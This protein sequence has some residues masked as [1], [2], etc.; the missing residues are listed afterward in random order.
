M[1]TMQQASRA[2]LELPRQVNIQLG[3]GRHVQLRRLDWISFELL[4]QEFCTLVGSL[5][6]GGID[7]GDDL[8]KQLGTAPQLVLKLASL[9]SGLDEAELSRWEHGSV[10][11]L[12]AAALEL[13]FNDPAGLRDF[14][15]ALARLWQHAQ[16]PAD[17]SQ[18]PDN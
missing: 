16:Q 7:N 8:L 6:D 2:V 9:S 18:L 1:D 17:H 5:P 10:L 4:W 14:S 11:E 3:N 13:N 12:A 15:S